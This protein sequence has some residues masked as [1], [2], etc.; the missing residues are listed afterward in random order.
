MISDNP[1]I[2]KAEKPAESGQDKGT[3]YAAH[4]TP[5]ENKIITDSR[6]A[7]ESNY[8]KPME[9][10]GAHAESNKQSWPDILTGHYPRPGSPVALPTPAPAPTPEPSSTPGAPR[11]GDNHSESGSEFD[12]DSVPFVIDLND[13]FWIHLGREP[14]AP[15]SGNHNPPPQSQPAEGRENSPPRPESGGNGEL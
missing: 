14:L 2:A 1:Y 7:A 4:I 6:K 3:K 5:V 10:T 15:V 12:D 11:H 9:I 13:P 8:V